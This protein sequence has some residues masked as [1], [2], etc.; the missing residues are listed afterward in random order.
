MKLITMAAA[1]DSGTVTPQSTYNDTGVIYVGGSQIY[2]WDLSGPGVTDMETLLARSLNIGAATLAM[3]M[4]PDSYYNY[5]AKFNFGRPMGVE[6]GAEASGLLALPGSPLWT[7]A[8]LVTNAFG[9]GF[10]TTSLQ[11]LTSVA[12]LANNG[13]MMKPYL[14]QEIRPA[15]GDPYIVEPQ[16][17]GRPISPRTAQQV[18]AMATNAV[19]REVLE[20]QVPGY[21]IAGKTGSA[22]IPENGVYHPDDIIGSF[23]GWLP[24]DDPELIIIVKIDRPHIDEAWGSTTAAPVFAALVQDLVT[25]LDIPPDNVR[26]QEDIWEARNGN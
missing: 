13:V 15:G 23:I 25:H 10:T 14:V 21:T 11:M 17:L 9:Q 6:L 4:G 26:L 20:A 24:A 22:Q 8:S 3:W 18:T 1:L 16:E 5:L 19:R 2:N 7:E 12:A